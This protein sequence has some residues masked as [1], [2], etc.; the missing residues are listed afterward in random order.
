LG[1]PT[2]STQQ[3][4]YEQTVV[5]D[6]DERHPLV[7]DRGKQ[8]PAPLAARQNR[9]GHAVDIVIN[10]SDLH[11]HRPGKLLLTLTLN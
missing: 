5:G 1:K 3:P 2:T 7:T 8:V 6:I 9:I 11:E 10:L 4:T